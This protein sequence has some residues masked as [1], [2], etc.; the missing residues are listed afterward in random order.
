M[1]KRGKRVGDCI[2]YRQ[3]GVYVV[4]DLRGNILPER[5]GKP[6]KSSR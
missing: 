4:T 1:A 2:I 6:V 3:N 5:S